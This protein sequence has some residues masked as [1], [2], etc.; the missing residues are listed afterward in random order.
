MLYMLALESYG[1]AGVATIARGSEAGASV[2]VGA[3][4]GADLRLEG[5]GAASVELLCDGRAWRWRAPGLA[6]GVV[7]DGDVMPLGR[8]ALYCFVDR[9]PSLA[10]AGDAAEGEEGDDA[11]RLVL[12]G[13]PPLVVRGH[14]PALVGAAPWC[15]LRTPGA[16]L[17][18][19]AVVRRDAAS[20]ST[21][22]HPIAGVQVLCAG[23][24]VTG[25]TPLEDGDA[26][27]V[28]GAALATP[29][30]FRDPQ[31]ELD[32]LLGLLGRDAAAPG[33]DAEAAPR[34][35]LLSRDEGAAVTPVEALLWGAALAVLLAYAALVVARY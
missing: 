23:R 29:L 18:V 11:P 32:R 4:R 17:P 26:I 9:A 1:S 21:A 7:R 6:T 12:G 33:D 8:W 5:A 28:P 14:A 35:R 16:R 2:S 13:A 20:R 34:R 22:L 10:P 15:A 27:E 3:E 30:V 31:R 24:L 25:R 19:L